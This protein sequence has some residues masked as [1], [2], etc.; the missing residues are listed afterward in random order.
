MCRTVKLRFL[1][2]SLCCVQSLVQHVESGAYV[3]RT[4]NS[5]DAW[6]TSKSSECYGKYYTQIHRQICRNLVRLRLEKTF[7]FFY[8]AHWMWELLI[9]YVP[10]TTQKGKPTHTYTYMHTL[11]QFAHFASCHILKALYNVRGNLLFAL[12]PNCLWCFLF[13]SHFEIKASSKWMFK[14][15]HQILPF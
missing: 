3:D 10:L 15:N 4:G 2:E 11:F 6:W 7:V 13:V 1:N 8:R 5:R 9:L 12:S 14:P